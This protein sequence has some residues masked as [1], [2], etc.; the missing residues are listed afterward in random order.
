MNLRYIERDGKMILQSTENPVKAGLNPSLWVDV[1]TVKAEPTKRQKIV[2]SLTHVLRGATPLVVSDV[3][4]LAE[5][6]LDYL[7]KRMPKPAYDI[8]L[9]HKALSDVRLALFGEA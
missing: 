4:K 7:E 8:G 9:Y 1:P 2:A 5:A 3:D 6:A